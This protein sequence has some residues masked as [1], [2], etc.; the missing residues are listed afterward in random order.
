MEED[1]SNS[2]IGKQNQTNNVNYY[3]TKMKYNRTKATNICTTQLTKL[4]TVKETY[5]QHV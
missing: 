3:I 5:G 1:D 2:F 4:F